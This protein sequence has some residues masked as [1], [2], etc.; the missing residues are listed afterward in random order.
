MAADRISDNCNYR[1]FE[2]PLPGRLGP[3]AEYYPL[4]RTT[5]LC[6]VTMSDKPATATLLPSDR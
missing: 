2:R 6:N 5:V 1:K 3:V 4:R